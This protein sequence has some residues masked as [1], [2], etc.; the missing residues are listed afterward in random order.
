M[1]RFTC[2]LALL[3]MGCVVLL[4]VGT[5]KAV[6]VYSENFTSGASINTLASPWTL[7]ATTG[8]YNFPIGTVPGGAK[9][10]LAGGPTDT[11]FRA[12]GYIPLP[13]SFNPTIHDYTLSFNFYAP[14]PDN[15]PSGLN[16]T[17]VCFSTGVPQSAQL[18]QAGLGFA[19][20]GPADVFYAVEQAVSGAFI[21][22]LSPGTSNATFLG[23]NDLVTIQTTASTGTAVITVTGAGGA[24]SSNTQ[25]GLNFSPLV[26][27]GLMMQEQAGGAYISNMQLTTPVPEPSSIALL[28]LGGVAGGLTSRRRRR[29]DGRV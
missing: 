4:T 8:G 7:A 6:V 17:G 20:S 22:A 2:C 3:I 28:G 11:G 25:S 26:G 1:S 5:A 27:G 10:V 24:T 12:V 18:G 16:N 14:L 21:T 13:A 19:V 23:Q 29:N 15:S 9:G